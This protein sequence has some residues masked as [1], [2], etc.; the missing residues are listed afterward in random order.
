MAGGVVSAVFECDACGALS[1]M[2]FI[3]QEDGRLYPRPDASGWKQA[4]ALVQAG[5]KLEAVATHCCE[6][7]E[8]LEES[9]E[10][11]KMRIALV[12]AKALGI[13]GV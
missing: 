3:Q 1:P 2:V 10:L 4:V 13:V 12:Q 7:P 11:Q 6:K 8:C 9:E 5:P